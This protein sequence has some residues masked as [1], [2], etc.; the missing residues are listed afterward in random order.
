M[1]VVRPL[2]P[3]LA[4]HD[5]MGLATDAELAAAIAALGTVY[6]PFAIDGGTP[7][8]AGAGLLDGGSP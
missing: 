8:A 2:H 6:A 3:P 4:I 1:I 5:A 7:A